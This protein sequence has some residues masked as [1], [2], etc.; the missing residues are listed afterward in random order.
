M[1]HFLAHCQEILLRRA[2]LIDRFVAP[3]LFN[4]QLPFLAFYESLLRR[5]LFYLTN[6]RTIK[7][8]QPFHPHT[9]GILIGLGGKKQKP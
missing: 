3:K 8:I 7:L 2:T 1:T 6:I 5:T 4:D 9:K